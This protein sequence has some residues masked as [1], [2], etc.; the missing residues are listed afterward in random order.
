MR[1]R[2][3]YYFRDPDK[4]P[5]GGHYHFDDLEERHQWWRE[6]LPL[7]R[8]GQLWDFFEKQPG[9]VR[10]AGHQLLETLLADPMQR[11]VDLY[12]IY[13]GQLHMNYRLDAPIAWQL[14]MVAEKLLEKA[15]KEVRAGRRLT[16]SLVPHMVVY[17]QLL[18]LHKGWIY[19]KSY[20]DREEKVGFRGGQRS[21][22]MRVA[23]R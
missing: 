12:Q 22:G 20:D 4:L 6:L 21:I 1:Y 16:R 15:K 14:V 3:S 9:D 17:D 7:R 11:D 5:E 10:L 2:R 8:I 13:R 23:C 19:S 18:L